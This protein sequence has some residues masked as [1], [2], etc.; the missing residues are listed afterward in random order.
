MTLPH[1]L[2]LA[3]IALCV[4]TPALAL[5]ATF[6]TT[7]APAEQGGIASEAEWAAFVTHYG[8]GL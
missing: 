3:I 1:I 4:T 2:A 6:R 5:L 7:A 8:D